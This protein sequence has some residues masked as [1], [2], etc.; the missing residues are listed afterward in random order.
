M[1]SHITFK[2]SLINIYLSFSNSFIRNF[3]CK[4]TNPNELSL[5]PTC[6]YNTDDD[7]YYFLAINTSYKYYTGTMSYHIT[8]W[9]FYGPHASCH[10][11]IFISF[12]S[13]DQTLL[14]TCAWHTRPC[15]LLF[16]PTSNTKKIRKPCDFLHIMWHFTFKLFV[17]YF[18]L[19]IFSLPSLPNNVDYI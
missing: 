13:V 12:P 15:H 7:D 17:F 3:C 2:F 18:C 1:S 9:F 8:H 16:E 11:S 14:L 4:F 10:S 5:L 6:V 19:P